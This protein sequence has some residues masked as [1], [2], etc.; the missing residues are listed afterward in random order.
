M[1]CTIFSARTTSALCLA[2][3]DEN[4]RGSAREHGEL[5]LLR[6]RRPEYPLPS[7][8]SGWV[9]F[10]RR[11]GARRS[12]FSSTRTPVPAPRWRRSS[13]LSTQVAGPRRPTS[14]Q[15]SLIISG[16]IEESENAVTMR[17]IAHCRLYRRAAASPRPRGPVSSSKPLCRRRDPASG[18]FVMGTGSPQ[19]PRPGRAILFS[20]RS[21]RA[22]STS[23]NYDD[24]ATF[25]SGNVFIPVDD[26]ARWGRACDDGG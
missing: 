20:L 17:F 26:R 8:R 4:L 11:S 7:S 18:R 10:V 16:T 14:D 21:S 12:C 13:W 24:N 22:R 23:F 19:T 9:G 1:T 15:R 25:N 6:L 3:A 5:G 2:D